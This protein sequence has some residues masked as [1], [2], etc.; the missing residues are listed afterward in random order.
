MSAVQNLKSRCAAVAV[1]MTPAATPQHAAIRPTAHTTPAR[2]PSTP[3][4]LTPLKPLCAPAAG[5]TTPQ[6]GGTAAYNNSTPRS[7]E[8]RKPPPLFNTPRTPISSQTCVSM[9]HSM[10]SSVFYSMF[11]ACGFCEVVLPLK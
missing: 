3:K 1:P 8:M 10:Y 9:F 6:M 5:M 4:S 7:A 11:K 2:N